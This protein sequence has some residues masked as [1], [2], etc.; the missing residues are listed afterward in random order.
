MS[1]NYILPVLYIY[2]DIYAYIL[3]LYHPDIAMMLGC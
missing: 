1:E 2:Q 3:L